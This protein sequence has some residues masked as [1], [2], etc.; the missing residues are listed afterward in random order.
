MGSDSDLVIV[1]LLCCYSILL[2]RTLPPH[3]RAI[4]LGRVSCVL[5]LTVMT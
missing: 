5:S 4:P 2:N 3:S 1:I